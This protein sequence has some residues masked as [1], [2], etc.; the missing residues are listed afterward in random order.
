MF[1]KIWKSQI[2]EESQRFS[3]AGGVKSRVHSPELTPRSQTSCSSR[4]V[5]VIRRRCPCTARDPG[6]HTDNT[7]HTSGLVAD[8]KTHRLIHCLFGAK[9]FAK[10]NRIQ[11]ASPI[12]EPCSNCNQTCACEHAYV[13]TCFSKCWDSVPTLNSRFP[14]LVYLL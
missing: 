7:N 2:R 14:H 5:C 10:C 6:T 9:L 3:S 13:M 11:I 4:L 12:T 8:S 1:S